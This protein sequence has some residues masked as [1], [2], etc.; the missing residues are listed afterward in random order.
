M[1]CLAS[2]VSKIK[3]GKTSNCNAYTNILF[4]LCTSFTG[5]SNGVI[6]LYLVNL[7]CV[8]YMK[9]KFKVKGK[10]ANLDL[11]LKSS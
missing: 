5:W 4:Y 9:V 2:G 1:L 8:I 3:K 7:E 6:F 10:C 11:E